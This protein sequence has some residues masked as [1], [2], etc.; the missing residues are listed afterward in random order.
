MKKIILSLAAL[1][2][3][4]FFT[5]DTF[6]EWLEPSLTEEYWIT[7][8]S[9]AK[10]DPK[11]NDILVKITNDWWEESKIYIKLMERIS[12]MALDYKND[13]EK[14]LFLW[15]VKE[16]V[17]NWIEVWSI[18]DVEHE[19]Y[20]KVLAEFIW[21]RND[22]NWSIWFLKTFRQERDIQIVESNKELFI[23]LFKENRLPIIDSFTVWWNEVF[24]TSVYRNIYYSETNSMY[25]DTSSDSF[26]KCGYYSGGHYHLAWHNLCV[27]IVKN[28]EDYNVVAWTLVYPWWYD[29]EYVKII[30]DKY[31]ML[32]T[33]S[34]AWWGTS[35]HLWLLD[36]DLN[37]LKQISMG[38]DEITNWIY[39]NISIDWLNLQ[40]H[41]RHMSPLVFDNWVLIDNTNPI[42]LTIW[43]ENKEFDEIEVLQEKVFT[44]Q[45]DYI[46]DTEK[47]LLSVY[48]NWTFSFTIWEE[49]Y[50]YDIQDLLSQDSIYTEAKENFNN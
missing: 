49:E 34:N 25:R 3:V 33:I 45:S 10:I 43:R 41:Q 48:E 4:F 39:D 19:E 6:A 23:D 15:Y 12:K 18:L 8:E 27:A 40:F 11:L 17:Q 22:I 13:R 9:E 31:I 37:M 1:L 16:Y 29:G 30:D 47:N 38:I 42:K 50:T 26:K 5:V 44:E 14:L 28:W 24:V 46:F 36:N 20:N 21:S 35:I 7:K 2:L 32:E